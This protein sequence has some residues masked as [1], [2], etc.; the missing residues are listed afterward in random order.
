MA[1]GIE[2]RVC[3]VCLAP[4]RLL[5][6]AYAR[7]VALR[8][9]GPVGGELVKAAV[10]LPVLCAHVPRETLPPNSVGRGLSYI[11]EALKKPV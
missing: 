1:L 2:A 11:K 5:T 6:L 10:P 8:V 7:Q 4:D 9:A 3:S